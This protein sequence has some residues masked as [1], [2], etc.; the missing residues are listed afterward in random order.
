VH[1][2]AKISAGVDDVKAINVAKTYTIFLDSCEVK[3]GNYLL[4]Y[5]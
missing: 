4:W 3:M 5:P 1:Y 2:I